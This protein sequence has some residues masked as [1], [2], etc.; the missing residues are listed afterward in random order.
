MYPS[1]QLE[2][3]KTSQSQRNIKK[4]LN[5]DKY[6]PL[7]QQA[8]SMKKIYQ[9]TAATTSRK[10]RFAE[11]KDSE[12]VAPFND[13]EMGKTRAAKRNFIQ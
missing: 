5:I 11:E 1:L 4:G 12:Q 7:L 13:Y 3:I 8:Q 9:E 6:M 10:T 2:L